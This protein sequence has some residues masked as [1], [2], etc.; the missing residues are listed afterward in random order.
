MHR[1]TVSS[2]GFS[3]IECCVALLFSAAAAQ[4]F[5]ASTTTTA[6][7]LHRLGDQ[8]TAKNILQNLYHRNR[9]ALLQQNHQSFDAQGLPTTENPVFFLN[10]SQHHEPPLL[11]LQFQ[12]RFHTSH[13]E[14]TT[15]RARRTFWQEHP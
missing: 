5:F 15:F 1:K 13:G 8:Q 7:S 12:L 10:I 11:H 14:A 3:F 6:K 9:A 2:F 4:L